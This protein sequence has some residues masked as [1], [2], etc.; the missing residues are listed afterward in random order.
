MTIQPLD[1]QLPLMQL[2]EV[3]RTQNAGQESPHAQQLVRAEQQVKEAA[4][5][6]HQVHELDRDDQNITPDGG[7]HG[8]GSQGR[9]GREKAQDDEAERRAAEP[10]KGLHIDTMR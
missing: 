8:G 7:G 1:V 5:K 4:L 10:D 2:D 6:E 9:S 3:S